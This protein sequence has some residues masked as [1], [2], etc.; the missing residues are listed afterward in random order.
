MGMNPFMLGG[1]GYGMP[2]P[3][4]GMPPPAALASPRG[5]ANPF[6]ANNPFSDG[7]ASGGAGGTGGGAFVGQRMEND[8]LNALTDELLGAR[9]K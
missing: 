9:P 7:G 8:P 1:G 6:S 5:G 2:H 4:Y 3:P